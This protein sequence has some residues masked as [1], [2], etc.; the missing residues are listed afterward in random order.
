[1]KKIIC[2][3]TLLF[4]A[5]GCRKDNSDVP[6]A[7]D[8]PEQEV[9]QDTDVAQASQPAPRFELVAAEKAVKVSDGVFLVG[10]IRASMSEDGS[11]VQVIPVEMTE[12]YIDWVRWGHKE[13][14]VDFD[15]YPDIGVSQYGGAKWGILYWWLYDPETKQFYSSP[16][17]EELNK[18]HH[19]KFWTDPKTSQIK[20]TRFNGAEITD[21]SYQYIEQ[22][23]RLVG[24][25]YIW[26]VVNGKLRKVG[27]TPEDQQ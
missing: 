15:G 3:F 10:W 21:Y 8:K 23:F 18:F 14:D 16:L 24:T 2:C 17:T 9:R 26:K 5:L 22:H 12:P 27:S 19:A 11:Q 13:L 25:R 20:I 4:L 6:P 7:T 1:M